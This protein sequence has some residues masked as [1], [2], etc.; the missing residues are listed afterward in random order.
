[1]NGS[2]STFMK[3]AL[4]VTMIVGLLFMVGYKLVDSEV[5]N[6]KTD[7][8]EQGTDHHGLNTGASSDRN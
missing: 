2:I 1:M 5:S 8:I 3:V 6:Y 4:T 7:L